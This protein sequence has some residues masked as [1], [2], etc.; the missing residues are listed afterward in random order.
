MQNALIFSPGLDGH[1]QVYV[2]VMTQILEELGFNIFIAANSQEKIV[3]SF[4]VKKLKERDD[5]TF[6]DTS[7]YA[8]GGLDITFSEFRALQNDCE[9]DLTIFA[10]ASNHISLFISRIFNVKKWRGRVVGIFMRPFYYY[11]PKNLV[12]KLKLLKHFSSRWNTD[13]ELFYKL[14]LKRFSLLDVSLSIDENFV[15]NNPNF[16]W[17]P[18]VFQ[19]Y[20]EVIIKSNEKCEQRHWIEKLKAFK[21]KNKDRFSFFYFG[22]AQYRRGYDILLKLAEE[23]GGC[24]IHCGLRDTDIK[25]SYD[26]NKIITSLQNEGRFFET[27]EYIDDPLCIEYFFRSV[28]HLVLPYRKFFGSSG[29]ML[30]ALEYGIPILAPHAGVMGY[31]IEKYNL[32]ITYTDSDMNSL[33]AQLEKFKKMD[34]KTFKKDIQNY[35]KLQSVDELKSVLVNSFL[36]TNKGFIQVLEEA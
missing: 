35:M 27:N 18:D 33:K 3:N 9:A 22:T 6:L 20:A 7:I 5:I 25:F 32:G 1:R 34:P 21:E 15:S 14:F 36:P 24:F 23:T 10:D 29:V 30:Q 4:Y 16:T 28:S 12:N 19:Q 13:E 17:L 26:T 8:S 2:F 11:R 31:R